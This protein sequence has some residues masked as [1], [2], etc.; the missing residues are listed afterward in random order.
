[1]SSDLKYRVSLTRFPKIGPFRFQKLIKFFNSAENIWKAPFNDLKR[2]NLEEK[3]ITDFITR[4]HE[5]NPDAEMEKLDKNNIKVL[6]FED[7]DYPKLLKEIYAPPYLLYYKG[8]TKCLNEF[9]VAIVGTRKATSY[10][11]QITPM[12]AGELA[13]NGVVIASGLAFGIDTLAHEAVV[14]ANGKT[15]GVLGSGLDKESFYPKQNL[16]LVEN[17]IAKS[18]IIISEHPIGVAPL[19]H[20]FPHRNRIISGL[21]LG[22][23]IVEAAANSGSLITAKS[24][25]EQ[26]REIFTVPGSIFSPVSA[27]P[28]NL[29][30][31]GAKPVTSAFDILESLNLKK[32]EDFVANQKIMPDTK[33]EK[34]ILEYLNKEPIHIDELKRAT[35]LDVSKLSSTL[36]MMEMK[37]KVKNIGG[38]NYVLGR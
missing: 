36:T 38:L 37:G 11:K 1:M 28:N 13:R 12:I 33:E 5:I 21:S 4:R 9:V 2:S 19:P 30:K 35:K 22:V 16:R 8:D 14:N 20:H 10:G 34:I 17:I 6:L 18:G 3:I 27:G 15:I 31:M 25:L 23:L 7:V 29:I 32:A 26:N 24:A